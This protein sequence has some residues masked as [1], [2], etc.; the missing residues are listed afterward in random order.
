MS[1]LGRDSE[2]AR[3]ETQLESLPTGPVRLLIEGEAGIGKTT[4]LLGGI[5][6]AEGRGYRVL[7]TRPA[8]ADGALPWSGLGD[9]LADVPDDALADLPE[10][11]HDALEVALLRRAVGVRPPDPR[12]VFTAFLNVVTSL[13]RERPIVVAVDDLQWLDLPSAR[14]L[15]FFGDERLARGSP[16]SRRR[17][18]STPSCLPRSPTGSRPRSGFA[19]RRCPSPRSITC[20]RNGS[21]CISPGPP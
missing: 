19:W 9:L 20:C 5:A 1:I 15:E 11:Q 12:A 17:A 2:L 6:A 18:S 21:A 4:V 7:E 8:E 10:P 14:A 13:A 16:C 3:L